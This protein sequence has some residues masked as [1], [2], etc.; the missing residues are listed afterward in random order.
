MSEP[1]LDAFELYERAERARAE[2]IRKS[3]RRRASLCTN[4]VMLPGYYGRYWVEPTYG[5]L[6]GPRGKMKLHTRLDGVKSYR[7]RVKRSEPL[8]WWTPRQLL[9]AVNRSFA[10]SSRT[11][12]FADSPSEVPHS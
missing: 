3:R 4:R 1:E 2:E 12:K 10:D 9:D 5:Q 8:K 7:I 11:E 6:F